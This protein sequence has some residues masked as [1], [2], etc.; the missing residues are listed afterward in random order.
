VHNPK[1]SRQTEFCGLLLLKVTV[2]FQGKFVFKNGRVYEGLFEDDHIVE[3]P[4][5][6]MDALATPDLSRIRTRTPLPYG[7]ALV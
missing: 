1:C 7:M 5:F 4:S 3:F 6:E 2:C